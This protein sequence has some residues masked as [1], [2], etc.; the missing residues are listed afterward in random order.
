MIIIWNLTGPSNYA[1]SKYMQPESRPILYSIANHYIPVIQL[2]DVLNESLLNIM[3]LHFIYSNHRRF[4]FSLSSYYT[5][6]A[7]AEADKC[8]NKTVNTILCLSMKQKL[9]NSNTKALLTLLAS[10]SSDRPSA[11]HCSFFSSS[12]A[13]A[14]LDMATSFT[15]WALATLSC[16]HNRSSE[17]IVVYKRKTLIFDWQLAV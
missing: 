17:V 11:L 12:I 6:L 8:K 16:K 9:M 15:S 10:K 3:T 2:T 5:N 1:I 13:W 7:W 14:R 4:V